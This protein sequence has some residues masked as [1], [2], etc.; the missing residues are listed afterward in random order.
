MDILLSSF[1]KKH[2]NGLNEK[3]LKELEIFLNMRMKQYS[4]FII[5]I[6]LVKI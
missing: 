6:F 2:I 3:Q 4:I 1:V 5:L